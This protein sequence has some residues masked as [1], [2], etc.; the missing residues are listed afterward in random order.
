[1]SKPPIKHDT[2][3]KS[4]ARAHHST[5]QSLTLLECLQS[6][7]PTISRPKPESYFARRASNPAPIQYP[8]TFSVIMTNVPIASE[9]RANPYNSLIRQRKHGTQKVQSSLATQVRHFKAHLNGQTQF[10]PAHLNGLT[11]TK[12]ARK[13]NADIRHVVDCISQCNTLLIT[14]KIRYPPFRF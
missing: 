10:A 11:A 9:P 5:L 7:T 1:M 8:Q 13:Y 14:Q 4:K 6:N 12:P 3:I 2:N